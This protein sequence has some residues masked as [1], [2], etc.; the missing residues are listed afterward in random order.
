MS[1]DDL[2]TAN[3]GGRLAHHAAMT[4]SAADPWDLRRPDLLLQAV[5]DSEPFDRPRTLLARVEGPYEQQQLAAV[6]CL[7]E[8]PAED[9]CERTR[10]TEQALQ[11]LGFGRGAPIDGCRP[12]TVPIVIRSGP[13]WFAWDESEAVLGLRYGGNLRNVIWYEVLTVTPRGWTSW[14]AELSGTQPRAEWRAAAMEPPDPLA[15]LES[16]LAATSEQLTAPLPDECLLHYLE[17]MLAEFGCRGHRFTERWA[18]GRKVRGRPVLAWAVANGGC[19]CDCEVV[20]NSFRRKA[21]RRKGL[22]CAEAIAELE[23]EYDEH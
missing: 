12:I 16:S 9:E 19:C 11:R 17:R 22:L 4:A 7:W 20:L 1:T 3:A 13:S 23:A 21:G 6:T 14:P 18:Q 5:A 8:E 15:E 2:W 10:L